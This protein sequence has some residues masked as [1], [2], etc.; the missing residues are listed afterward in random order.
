MLLADSIRVLS[1]TPDHATKGKDVTASFGKLTAELKKERAMINKKSQSESSRSH[2][3]GSDSSGN[4]SSG[5]VPAPVV[6]QRSDPKNNT[7]L[8][9]PPRHPSFLNVSD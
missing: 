4:S 7:A 1:P 8:H 6:T 9:V 2:S 3:F 5:Y